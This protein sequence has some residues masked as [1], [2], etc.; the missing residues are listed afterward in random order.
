MPTTPFSM[1]G[2][3]NAKPTAVGESGYHLPMMPLLSGQDAVDSL[4]GYYPK[5]RMDSQL[6]P[7]TYQK[8]MGVRSTTMPNTKTA[9]ELR[10]NF[11]A[12]KL[13][14]LD[15]TKS[16]LVRGFIEKCAAAD[17]DP[18]ATYDAVRDAM[19]LHPA[20]A[21]EF[22]KCGMEK[23]AIGSGNG[24]YL[25]GVT[26][27]NNSGYVN[28]PKPAA[29]KFTSSPMSS[30]SRAAL[31]TG[32]MPTPAPASQRAMPAAPKPST[33]SPPAQAQTPRPP[34]PTGWSSGVGENTYNVV[35]GVPTALGAGLGTVGTGLWSG[36][37]RL[38]DWSGLTDDWTTPADAATKTMTDA[39][40]SGWANTVAG[41]S[42]T[43]P[44]LVAN[45]MRK[46][47]YPDA[48]PVSE[49]RKNHNRMLHDAGQGEQ[50]GYYNMLTGTSDTAAEMIPA[51][52]TR[53]VPGLG[54]VS[55][56]VLGTQA[57][58]S[59]VG[60][61]IV[62]TAT[63]GF[64]TLTGQEPIS[65]LPQRIAEQTP[66]YQ[67]GAIHPD[68]AVTPPALF[69]PAKGLEQDLHD[70]RRVPAETV[71]N[72]RG[73]APEPRQPGP[74]PEWGDSITT[75]LPGYSDI[76]NFVQQAPEQAKGFF[77]QTIGQLKD[78]FGNS[79][80]QTEIA[81]AMK[82]GDLGPAGQRGALTALTQ[83]GFDWDTATQLYGKMSLPEKIGLWGGV[84]LAGIGLINAM[85]GGNG[86]ASIL[87]TLLGLGTA[88]FSAGMGGLL[89]QGSQD[90]TQGV[91]N[92]V[93]GPKAQQLPE[94][95][96]AHLP[97]LLQSMPDAAIVPMLQQLP[98]MAPDVAKQLD[99]AAGVGSWGNSALSWFGDMTGMRQN[100]MQQALGL[101]AGQ[102]D[103]L[104][105]LWTQMR[106]Q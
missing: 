8:P 69:D 11:L 36:V 53:K 9:E 100:K 24:L 71:A 38:T 37:T 93:A 64:S 43:K 47:A 73:Q 45:E 77:D 12:V 72:G 85:A 41:I 51:A 6:N 4:V 48:V 31:L 105:K 62:P 30:P 78:F 46:G 10:R 74:V 27:G 22:E 17:L 23:K 18:V 91:S 42:G 103:R 32:K 95:V 40:H 86:L 56:M 26:P 97:K 16:A 88:G 87:M 83:E 19:Q 5:R 79:D 25:P 14:M 63:E 57:I 59:P 13:A 60:E 106:G 80:A 75:Q 84:G 94:M 54:G 82:N 61:A 90:F 99:Q 92:A 101:D 2:A 20:V 44:E 52:V 28:S 65:T 34:D 21:D 76:A 104:L 102:Q 96:K 15:L 66:T 81:G 68:T 39:V 3:P 7:H 29:P 70:G 55:N 35:R 58:Q 98:A 1:L 50:A 49:M 33:P 67:A 89:D